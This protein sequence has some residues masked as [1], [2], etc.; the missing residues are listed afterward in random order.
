MDALTLTPNVF[1]RVTLQFYIS[2][3]NTD[4][5]INHFMINLGSGGA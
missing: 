3:Q 2:L 4:R 1:V 5:G